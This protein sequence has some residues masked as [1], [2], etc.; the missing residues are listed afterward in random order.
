MK[1][2]N[3]EDCILLN[4][5]GYCNEIYTYTTNN[6]KYI[7][8]KL[9][10]QDINRDLEYKIQ[11]LAFEQ[12]IT[13][14]PILYSKEE[15]IMIST[16]IDGV[17]KN[18][19]NTSN[20]KELAMSLN[21][22]H[23]I[24]YTSKPLDLESIINKSE[25]TIDAFK[26]INKYLIENVLCHNDLNPENIIFSDIVKFIDWEYSS[27]ND[28]YFDLASICVEFKLNKN[29]EFLFLNTYFGSKTIHEDKLNAY[30]VLYIELCQQWFYENTI[31]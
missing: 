31:K 9:L 6:I 15:N 24:N 25:K 7:I 19:L 21:K 2:P 3:I 10:R 26:T 5:Q 22:L 23:K 12:N 16:F 13:S 1:I 8:R 14:E 27:I 18:N 20:I 29:E 28:R 30:K 11:E 17:H 4:K